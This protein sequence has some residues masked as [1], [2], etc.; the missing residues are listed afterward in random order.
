MYI[1]FSS[2]A[3]QFVTYFGVA[4]DLKGCNPDKT[5]FGLPV[6]YKYLDVPKSAGACNFNGV[7]IWPPNDLLL[8][9][10][11]A[12]DILMRIAGM[13]AVAYII[14]GGISY[15]LSQGEPDKTKEAQQTIINALIGLVVTLI[16]VAIVSF[17]GARLKG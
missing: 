3:T 8:I 9:A 1:F 17:L 14:W 4:N 16:A 10:V 5:F 15:V 11:V 13:V 7:Q 2:L 12:L 6:W